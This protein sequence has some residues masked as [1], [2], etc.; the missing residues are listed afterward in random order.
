[1]HYEVRLV[2]APKDKVWKT[3]SD[4]K[5]DFIDAEE[6]KVADLKE[7][8]SLVLELH[9]GDNIEG[10]ME[11]E[12]EDHDLGTMVI[13]RAFLDVKGPIRSLTTKGKVK[14]ELR[15]RVDGIKETVEDGASSG[16]AAKTT[17]GSGGPTGSDAA[18]KASS[19]GSDSKSSA[20]KKKARSKSS[21]PKKS[22]A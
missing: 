8:E 19:Q 14:K 10:R 21:G 9:E 17:G 11:L 12:L 1:M 15:A 4:L 18:K 6:I 13:H 2:R 7:K 16:T 22:K 20:S 5:N 3:V